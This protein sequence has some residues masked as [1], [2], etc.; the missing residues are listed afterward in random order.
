VAA[1]TLAEVRAFLVAYYGNERDGGS[2]FD[3]MRTLSTK[4]RFGLVTVEGV[5][6]QLVDIGMRML[7][8]R[9]LYR[10]QGFPD[11]YKIDIEFR[12]KPLSKTAQVR[13][14]GNSVCPD[15]AA[16]IISA[17]VRRA[18]LGSVPRDARQA[19]RTALGK[20]LAGVDTTSKA[21]PV[22]QHILFDAEP[23]RLTMTATNFDAF[24]RLSVS[25][26]CEGSARA[27]LPAKLLAEIV[28]SLPPAPVTLALEPAA[29]GPSSAIISAGRSRFELPGLR[30][31]EFPE[32]PASQVETV[33]T[34]PTVAF[35]DALTRAAG[36]TSDAETRPALNGVLVDDANGRM[37]VIGCDGAALARIGVGRNAGLLGG[38]CLIHRLGVPILTKLFGGAADAAP[39]AREAS[40]TLALDGA[41]RLRA[42]SGDALALVR[43]IDYEYPTTSH[44]FALDR[45]HVVV[46]DR[47][48]LAAAVRRVSV[49]AG[50]TLRI[51]I[52]LLESEIAIRA[53]ADKTG[54]ASDVVP[55]DTHQ[56]YERPARAD[57][58]PH[59]PIPDPLA[60][61]LNATKLALA[62]ATL[63]GNQVELTFES[64][65]RPVLM[66]D[67]EQ[68]ADSPTFLAT[69]P[70][71]AVPAPHTAPRS[72]ATR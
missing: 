4:D 43:L 27:L 71:T 7:A 12:G 20:L 63:T 61:T 22:A 18:A 13:M 39:D 21:L 57:G 66:R 69:M 15:V 37:S 9:E 42:E 6:Y 1:S 17:N 5:D 11:S 53:A 40:L 26:Q 47:V 50:D 25:C 2:L 56:R 34:V 54:R 31:E 49:A 45:T 38:R 41:G 32:L 52:T 60:L 65:A 67:P 30:P 58:E 55:L 59:E 24:V 29:T 72:H 19:L 36:F 46:C 28:A 33:I 68:P 70:L 23:G 10:A 16:A 64:P 3:P 14:C 8:P 48:H 62:L 51:E 44:V 35:L